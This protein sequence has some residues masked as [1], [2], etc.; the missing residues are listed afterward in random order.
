MQ[1]SPSVLAELAG[2]YNFL[3]S[4]IESGPPAQRD[5]KV[6]ATVSEMLREI[7][8]GGIDA[9]LAYAAKLDH[10]TAGV[11]ELS[12][13]GIK[14]SGERITPE[15]R[16]ALEI[17]ADRTKRFAQETRSHL[18]DFEVELVPGLVTGQKYVPVQ[19]VGAYLPPAVF[20]SWPVRS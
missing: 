11:V 2:K 16:R 9:V 14:A 8:A 7:E 18:V 5:P 20:R 15:L 19:R 3:K 10:P 1:L 13:A 4:P 17:G 6:I 12:E